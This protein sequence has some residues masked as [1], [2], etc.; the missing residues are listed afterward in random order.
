MKKNSTKRLCP[1]EKLGLFSMMFMGFCL[2][3]HALNVTTNTLGN[4]LFIDTNAETSVVSQQAAVHV[5]KGKVCDASGSPLPGVAILVKGT[6]IGSITDP[7][8]NYSI[9]LKDTKN[10]V[11]VFSFIGMKTQEVPL[12]KRSVVNV[13]LEEEASALDEV[14][15]TGYFERKKDSYTGSA[16]TFKG[17]ELREI[18]T[19]NVL[20]TLSMVD[21]SFKLM[22]NLE[23][24]SNPNKIPEFTIHGN[25]NLQ[26]EYENS[27]NMP[28]F[29]LDGFEVSPEKVFD[30]DPNRVSTITIL[31]DA[32]ATAIYGSRAAN[33]VV[34][35]ETKAPL[36]GDIRVSYNTSLDFEVADLS[37]YNLMNAEEKLEYER[38]ARLYSHSNTALQEELLDKYN[39]RLALVRR[40]LDTDWIAKPIKEIGFSHKHSLYI[41]G[42]DSKLRYGLTLNYQDKNGVMRD[43]GRD[44]LGIGVQLQY[45]YKNLK[46]MNDLTYG[47]IKMKNSP[48][49]NFSAYTWLN[50]YYYP[51]YD[52][53]NIKKILHTF[54]TGEEVLNPMYNATL[55]TK[56]EQV[57]DEFINNFSLEWDIA[58][59]LRLKTKISLNQKNSTNDR[60]LPG[61]HTAFHGSSLNGSYS[62]T[63]SKEFS[64]DTHATLSYSKLL[65][66]HQINA[67]ALWNVRESR[68]DSYSTIAYNFPNS[69][70]DH[71]GMGIQ[72]GKGDKPTGNYEISRLMGIVGNFNYGYDDRYLL[73]CSVR[74][75]GSS[76]FGSEKRWGTFGSVGLGWNL[77]NESWL[78]GNKL[79]NRLQLR[80]SWGTTGGQKFYPF[81]SMLMYSY[82]DP[83][84]SG[85]H[86][87]YDGFIGALIKAYG[88]KNLKWQKTEKL[89]A[90]VD[91]ILLDNR[92][93]GYLNFY[94]E[95]SKSVLTD[96]SVAPSLGFASYKDNLGQVENKG[97]EMNLKAVLVRDRA[98]N[99]QWDVF[100]NVVANKNRLLKLNDA[101]VA[102]NK[103]QDDTTDKRGETGPVVR[104]QEGQS[105]NTIWANQSLGIDPVTGNEVFLDMD[106]KRVVD[107]STDNYKPLGCKDPDF[108]GNFGTMFRYKG[109]MMQAYFRYSCGGDIYNQTLVD[110]VENVKPQMNADKRVLY[111]RWKHMG[112]H[113]KFKSIM[114]TT[115]T[116]PTSRFIEE[117]N[118]LSLSSLNL[119]YEFRSKKL[120]DWGVS[121]VKLSAIGNELFR[122][123][124]VKMERGIS[125]PFARTFSL[126]GQITF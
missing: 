117:Q 93:S 19:G 110:K 50:P 76:L 113:A 13:K 67:V 48:Y 108:E 116:M 96:V 22:E 25:G 11:L 62:K 18:S 5:V 32:A 21:P 70:I 82:K 63:S 107:W 26:T 31:K 124:T 46:F 2:N 109:F 3:S 33:G 112:D 23:A 47:Q 95:T 78:K 42:G 66:K 29:I 97:V 64:Y 34:I 61:D 54:E 36:M 100:L 17:D 123:S 106:G 115:R 41:E 39:E 98:K 7:D 122:T 20:S 118:Y 16:T 59:G 71:I 4:R 49:G 84:L 90:G 101:L 12:G 37:D 28:T 94:K 14:V 27:P 68:V 60:F 104:Y 121:R 45:R 6:T 40:G 81:Q 69:N 58:E 52:N 38:R 125:Y 77:H 35:V 1:R 83:L 74:S 120:R 65:N 30:M 80:G 119:S 72:Y 88:N 43:S 105:I 55:G 53:G 51:Y 87:G 44:N 86:S 24:G 8:G 103:K 10:A 73:D 79:V 99:I 111:D 57:Y 114:N 89:S 56:D 75:D 102:W 126:A 91:F 9:Q 15:V 92:L 85:S